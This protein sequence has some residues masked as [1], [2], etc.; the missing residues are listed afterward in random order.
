IVSVGECD[1]SAIATA[2]FV[3]RLHAESIDAVVAS[4]R[5]TPADALAPLLQ[6]CENEGI[7]LL[8]RPDLPVRAGWRLAIDHFGGEPVLHVRSQSAAPSHLVVKQIADY[9]LAAMLLV[10][11][12]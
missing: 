6:A 8:L 11:T 5:G 9:L 7:E 1:P 12:L 3:R 10:L 2:E 4:V